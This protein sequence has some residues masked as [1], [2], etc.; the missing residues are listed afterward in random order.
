MTKR[1]LSILLAVMLI[2]TVTVL[3]SC[4]DSD[5][6]N[7][8]QTLDN[9]DES[10]TAADTTEEGK[11]TIT[12]PNG[13]SA[14]V[15]ST[16]SSVVTVSPAAEN[17]FSRLSCDSYVTASYSVTDDCT[18]SIVSAAPDVVI[19]DTG[20]NIDVDTITSAGIVAVEFPTEAESVTSIKND[21][22][23]FVGTLMGVSYSSEQESLQKGLDQAKALVAA[24]TTWVSPTVYFEVSYEDGTCYTVAPYSYIYE[25]ISISGGSNVFGSSSDYE[26]FISVSEDDIIA[27]NPSIIFT[28]GLASDITEREGW[29]EVS[30]VASGNV[31]EITMNCSYAAAEAAN[32]MYQ[33]FAVYLGFATEDDF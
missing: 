10:D 12:L 25:I 18:D 1:I 29:S 30:A 4:G 27:A 26:G 17:I 31:Y 32:T 14:T 2:M 15:P 8:V 3:S 9:G 13:D 11:T 7:T 20:A 6:D 22:I 19:Y 21:Y 33:Y 23:K 28:V 5:E 16:I 24:Q